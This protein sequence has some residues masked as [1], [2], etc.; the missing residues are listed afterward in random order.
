MLVRQ[1]DTVRIV[2]PASAGPREL[3]AASRDYLK[4]LGLDSLAS[5]A[6]LKPKQ[7]LAQS[8]AFRAEDFYRGFCERD[9]QLVWGLRGGYGSLRI[10]SDLSKRPRPRQNKIFW[11][12]SDLSLLLNFI[13][14]QW[15]QPC[16]HGPVLCRLAADEAGKKERKSIEQLLFTS[17]AQKFSGLRQINS[18]VVRKSISS[19][20][21]GGNLAS[22]VS[23][24]GTPFQL[25]CAGK[26]VLLEDV[27][28]RG[29]KL[30]RMLHSLLLATDLRKAKA[31]VLGDFSGGEE[32]DGRRLVNYALQEFARSLSIP[33][34]RG[35]STGHGPVQYPVLLYS[36]AKLQI[37]DRRGELQCRLP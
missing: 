35:L 1:G 32:P 16:V 18:V 36:P 4:G 2:A 8:D 10:L 30:D 15:Q 37:E 27:G 3:L 11:G 9:S 26:I 13:G 20:V 33:V 24:L 25:S 6:L 17:G 28:E 19:E 29:Y 7:Y 21:V 14:Q 12:L 34:L 23:A 22:L 31:I 5:P